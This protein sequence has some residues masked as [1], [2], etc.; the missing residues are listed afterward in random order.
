M[1][2]REQR[3]ENFKNLKEELSR[4][5]KQESL[6][7]RRVAE[8]NTKKLY[9]IRVLGM[10]QKKE[11][12]QKVKNEQLNSKRKINYFW[13]QKR[14]FYTEQHAIETFENE[15]SKENLEKELEKLENIEVEFLQRLENTQNLQNKL[16]DRYEETFL[17]SSSQIGEIEKQNPKKKSPTQSKKITNNVFIKNEGE[18][19]KGK[20]KN[21]NN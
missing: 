16:Y 20:W 1:D 7:I 17:M 18:E 2:I 10:Q 4:M 3:K 14:R 5:K 15:K 13:E 9:E 19:E 6:D 21:N 12:V 11:K 8:E